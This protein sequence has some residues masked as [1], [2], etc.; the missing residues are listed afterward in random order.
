[1]G[2]P[3]TLRLVDVCQEFGFLHIFFCH[4]H[5]LL[6][7]FTDMLILHWHLSTMTFQMQA[8]VQYQYKVYASLYIKGNGTN[9]FAN[10]C[11]DFSLIILC[12][13][14]AFVKKT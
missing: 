2:L 12:G 11:A 10:N 1:M 4:T 14:S 5:T 8:V 13:I 9:A 7:F 3:L 6:F